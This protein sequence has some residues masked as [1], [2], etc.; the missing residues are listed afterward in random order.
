[1]LTLTFSTGNR[2]HSFFPKFLN[3]SRGWIYRGSHRL[4]QDVASRN[5]RINLFRG[6]RNNNY[7]NSKIAEFY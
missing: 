5:Y 1:M 4:L 2:L 7:T 3:Q 6:R